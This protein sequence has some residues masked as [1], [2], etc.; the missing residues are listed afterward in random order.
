MKKWYTLPLF[1]LMLFAFASFFNPANAFAVGCDNNDSFT[2]PA[3]T[4]RTLVV[5]LSTDNSTTDN[6]TFNGMAL[7]N[8]VNRDISSGAARI[9]IFY[10]HLGTSA[11]PTSG[12][13]AVG[14]GVT[15]LSLIPLAF[16]NI[17][18]TAG[19]AVQ[20]ANDLYTFPPPG[21]LA[22]SDITTPLNGVY[23]D[24]TSYG[25]PNT[26]LDTDAS[27]CFG[28]IDIIPGLSADQM[29]FAIITSDEVDP[30]WY[31]PGPA[32]EVRLISATLA[33]TPGNVASPLAFAN[34]SACTASTSFPAAACP[35]VV[36]PTPSDVPTLSEWGLILLALLLMTAG[37]LY[38]VQPLVTTEK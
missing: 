9:S 28:Q 23:V 37:T 4:D 2:V 15:V 21:G 38:L 25:V 26:P 32:T 14:G 22:I 29:S 24:F 31:N 13:I 17:L 8:I 5:Y 7:T 3:G 12:T 16:E 34:T 6:L 18:Q 20:E 11:V 10:L 36:P 27:G 35:V 30:F 33:P 1:A 19:A